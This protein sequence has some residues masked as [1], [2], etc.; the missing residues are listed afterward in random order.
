MTWCKWFKNLGQTLLVVSFLLV[1]PIAGAANKCSNSHLDKK[2]IKSSLAL[3][4]PGS[5]EF[6]RVV[7]EL[8]AGLDST[9]S[10]AV[11]DLRTLLPSEVGTRIFD[12]MPPEPSN[13]VFFKGDKL[14]ANEKMYKTELSPIISVF[15]K[16]FEQVIHAA[17]IPVFLGTKNVEKRTALRDGSQMRKIIAGQGT[18]VEGWHIDGGSLVIT[19]ALKGPGTAVLGPLESYNPAERNDS[20]DIEKLTKTA[21]PFVVPEGHALFFF[22]GDPPAGF[23]P[24]VH[25]S[26]KQDGDRLLYILRKYNLLTD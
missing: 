10:Y 13:A 3:P 22:A 6:R 7:S 19:M 4:K 25:A 18:K 16:W 5:K 11:V 9:R 26:P 1:G 17:G 24:T 12:M 2:D 8:K 23:Y 15:D 20:R 14:S 21:E